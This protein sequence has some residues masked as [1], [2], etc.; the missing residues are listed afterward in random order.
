MCRHPQNPQHVTP[1]VDFEEW[2]ESWKRDA[3][4]RRKNPA[5]AAAAMIASPWQGLKSRA[6]K[7]VADV[8]SSRSPPTVT[9]ACLG[10]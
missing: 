6:V 8:K 3:D 5:A 4:K 10:A 1:E 2:Y 7:W 9:T